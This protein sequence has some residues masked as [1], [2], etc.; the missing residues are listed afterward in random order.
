MSKFDVHPPWRLASV[1][2]SGSRPAADVHSKSETILDRMG[3]LARVPHRALRRIH[4][5]QYR[6]SLRKCPI[7]QALNQQSNGQMIAN[8]AEISADSFT[9]RPSVLVGFMGAAVVSVTDNLLLYLVGLGLEV[10]GFSF[11]VHRNQERRLADR[12]LQLTARLEKNPTRWARTGFRGKVNRELEGIARA[13]ERM[14]RQLRPSDPATWE[15]AVQRASVH[16]KAIRQLKMG[17][18]IPTDSTRLDLIQFLASNL[19]LVARGTWYALPQAESPSP[20]GNPISTRVVLT[21]VTA[22][23][24]VGAVIAAYNEAARPVAA[25][26]SVVA[27]Y[28]LSQ[29]GLSLD[30]LGEAAN[31]V[32]IEK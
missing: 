29:R 15:W 24:L 19:E 12:I 5:W 22:V 26:L 7:L 6:L 17:V 30:A 27:V 4:R 31:I 9:S 21:L 2:S 23:A 10:G 14:P 18:I 25:A 3:R 20:R 28:F 11:A 32:R 13:L 16:A 8:L 1:P